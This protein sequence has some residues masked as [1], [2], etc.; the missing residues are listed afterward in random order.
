MA[1]VLD[2]HSGSAKLGAYRTSFM[3]WGNVGE[4]RKHER[5][6]ILMKTVQ[7][8]SVLK[9]VQ[10]LT[11]STLVWAGGGWGWFHTCEGFGLF[12]AFFFARECYLLPKIPPGVSTK[13]DFL[14]R[15]MNLP[16]L[17][18]SN[19]TESHLQWFWRKRGHLLLVEFKTSMPCLPNSFWLVG[20]HPFLVALNC[21][22]RLQN[23][24]FLFQLFSLA[25]Q[26]SSSNLH[27]MCC[28][29]DSQIRVV[30]K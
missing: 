23:L 12:C 22:S 14:T 8:R 1:N 20:H 11:L 30:K 3:F 24:L 25:V 26:T 5:K 16:G 17:S 27:L 6:N 7:T 13:C 19:W 18:E 9:E 4:I 21:L 29:F 28:V 15:T 2:S 10:H